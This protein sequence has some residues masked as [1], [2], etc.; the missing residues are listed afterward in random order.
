[1][2]GSLDDRDRSFPDLAQRL[3][4]LVAG[5]ATIGEDVPQPGVTA[6]DPGQDEQCTITVLD[7]GGVDHGMNKIALGFGHDVPL[8]ALDLLARSVAPMARR[9]RWS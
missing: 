9:S 6:D 8:A 3:A 4:Q 2:V 1:M 7:I 5:I